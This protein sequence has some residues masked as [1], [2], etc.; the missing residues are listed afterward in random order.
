MAAIRE[1]S[2]P[3]TKKQLRGILGFFSYFCKHIE[4]FAE[5]AKLLTD[6]T[7]K[8]VP[9]TRPLWNEKHSEA[10]H[11][12]KLDLISACESHLHTT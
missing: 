7:P 11:A 12:L 4:A 3:E 1:M 8:R 2:D 9:Q 6:L 5:K 10:L